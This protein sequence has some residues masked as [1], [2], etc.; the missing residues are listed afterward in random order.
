M[1][2]VGHGVRMTIDVEA[3][4]YIMVYVTSRI[5]PVRIIYSNMGEDLH[6]YYKVRSKR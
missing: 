4:L 1:T 6:S 3:L 5:R 2:T